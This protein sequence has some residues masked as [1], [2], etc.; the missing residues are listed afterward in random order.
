MKFDFHWEVDYMA[1]DR[2]MNNPSWCC[3]KIQELIKKYQNKADNTYSVEH[4][5]YIDI[6]DD[7]EE[8]LYE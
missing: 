5:V 4:E 6:I 1:Q 7:L 3:E 2:K 8:I